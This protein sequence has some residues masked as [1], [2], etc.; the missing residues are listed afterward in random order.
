MKQTNG[1]LEK[2]VGENNLDGKVG[3]AEGLT[4]TSAIIR[5]GDIAFNADNGGAGALKDG[6]VISITP[7]PSDP[8]IIYG[9]S[10]TA[11]MR[12]AKAAMTSSILA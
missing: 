6:S 8:S 4:S 12:G 10:E 1:L 7:T 9:S 3:I 11:M 5:L 2:K